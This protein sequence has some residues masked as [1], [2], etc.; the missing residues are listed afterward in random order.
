[1]FVAPKHAHVPCPLFDINFRVT[2]SCLFWSKRCNSVAM[3][4]FWLQKNSKHNL[5][6]QMEASWCLEGNDGNTSFLITLGSSSLY[7]RE[8]KKNSDDVLSWKQ[9]N[10]EMCSL[11]EVLVTWNDDATRIA[12]L[13]AFWSGG[14]VEAG[15][16][17]SVFPM[18]ELDWWAPRRLL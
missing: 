17:L 7:R 13:T 3:S 8:T 9:I 6:Q 16:H 2:N 12:S 10:V 14:E 15:S 5:R 1:M 18:S 4:S 11:G